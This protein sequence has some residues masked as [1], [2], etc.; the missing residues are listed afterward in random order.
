MLTRQILGLAR[1]STA[2]RRA[3]ASYPPRLAVAYPSGVVALAAPFFFREEADF[4]GL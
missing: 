4:L 3:R 2:R 1:G